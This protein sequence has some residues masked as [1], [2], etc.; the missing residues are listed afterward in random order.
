MP[1]RKRNHAPVLID[2]AGLRIEDGLRNGLPSQTCTEHCLSQ[3]TLERGPRVGVVPA[4]LQLS[5][6]RTGTLLLRSTIAF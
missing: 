1:H 6:R 5:R 4:D 2:G 3:R